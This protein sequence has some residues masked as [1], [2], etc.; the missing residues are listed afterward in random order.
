M[1]DYLDSY[2]DTYKLSNQTLDHERLNGGTITLATPDG[3]VLSETISNAVY[4]PEDDVCRLEFCDNQIMLI[5][6]YSDLDQF[7]VG[8]WVTMD[9]GQAG[10]VTLTVEYAP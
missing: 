1:D 3:V 7:T 8:T 5:I 10:E 4:D 9:L 6:C 2:A